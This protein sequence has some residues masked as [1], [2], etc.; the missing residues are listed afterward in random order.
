VT[1]GKKKTKKQKEKPKFWNPEPPAHKKL[2]HATLHRESKGAPA[3]M[4]AP[5]LPRRHRQT[6][7]DAKGV[8]PELLRLEFYCSWTGN[9]FFFS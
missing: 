2:L 8:T 4:L 7:L 6:R 5:N 3:P 9:F 1:L